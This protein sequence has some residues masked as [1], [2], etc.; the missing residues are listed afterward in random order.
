MAIQL[1]NLKLTFTK[2][3]KGETPKNPA[4]AFDRPRPKGFAHIL[5]GEAPKNPGT[6]FDKPQFKNGLA[7]VFKGQTNTTVDNATRAFLGNS[8]IG[9][10]MATSI[11][12]R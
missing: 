9:A 1:G 10:R 11:K 4:L 7:G 6:L 12:P 8:G 3:N 5:K 2:I